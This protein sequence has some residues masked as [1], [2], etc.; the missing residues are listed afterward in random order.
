MPAQSRRNYYTE[1]KF[2]L[3]SLIP[4]IGPV[5]ASTRTADDSSSIN[6]NVGEKRPLLAGE[7]LSVPTHVL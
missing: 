4:D 1:A 3:D 7:V 5:R 6:A 2:D